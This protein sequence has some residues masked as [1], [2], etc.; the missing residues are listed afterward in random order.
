MATYFIRHYTPQA[1]DAWVA[2]DG[3]WYEVEFY[4]HANAAAEIIGAEPR[5]PE[6]YDAG[7]TLMSRGWVHISGGRIDEPYTACS[8]NQLDAIEA[9]LYAVRDAIRA[10]GDALD[11]W[12]FGRHAAYERSAEDTLRRYGRG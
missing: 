1:T 3:T 7:E 10:M 5:S 6:A 12:T 2:P 4:N 8:E 11:S 9:A